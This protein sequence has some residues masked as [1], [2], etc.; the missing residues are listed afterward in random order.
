VLTNCQLAREGYDDRDI[1]CII[2][3]MPHKAALPVEQEIGRGTRLPTGID[4]LLEAIKNGVRLSKD[5][6]IILSVQDIATKHELFDV[7]T[8]FGLPTGMDLEGKS[9]TYAKK[10]YEQVA[11]EYPTADL[12]Q[13]KSLSKLESVSKSLE[14]FKVNYPPEIARM[15]EFA[16]RKSAEGYM[17]AFNRDLVTVAQ[18]LRGDWQIRGRIGEHVAELS[19][20]NLPGAMNLADKFVV[21]SGG[22]RTLLKR[23]VRWHNDAP[24]SKQLSLCHILKID[25]PPGATKGQ[26]SAAID[27]KRAQLRS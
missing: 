5:R 27:A 12:S 15:S 20:Q 14:L 26:V 13:I 19:A 3:G 1:E 17:L 7:P 4:N 23:D 8:L 21:D 2:L 18:D 16:W 22:V 11:K 10:T 25:V 6:C 24:T 9:V